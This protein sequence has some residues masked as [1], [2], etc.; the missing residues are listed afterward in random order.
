MNISYGSIII[1]IPDNGFASV[2]DSTGRTWTH[3]GANWTRP[4]S[5]AN[6]LHILDE[7]TVTDGTGP[8]IWVIT[9]SGALRQ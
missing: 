8:L 4:N 3:S 7:I 6:S 9:A 5:Q 2:T 1:S